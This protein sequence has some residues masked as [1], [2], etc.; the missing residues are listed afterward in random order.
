MFSF[1]PILK[2]EVMYV[3]IYQ[4]FVT[5][6]SVRYERIRY[7]SHQPVNYFHYSDVS[8]GQVRVRTQVGVMDGSHKSGL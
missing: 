8:D 2:Y 5:A 4:R 1:L 6:I 3:Y 7:L